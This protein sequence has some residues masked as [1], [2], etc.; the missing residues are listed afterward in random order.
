[1]AKR[2]RGVSKVE[3]GPVAVDGG[4]CADADLIT[5]G[6]T[7]RDSLIF[8][9]TDATVQ[10]FYVEEEDDPIDSDET[11]KG[12]ETVAWSTNNLEG[13]N[14]F[15]L[16]GG[17]HLPYK[18]AKTLGTITPGSG[19]TNGTYIRV[20]LTGGA[21]KGA[22]ATIVVAGGV[23]TS[24]TLTY[25]GEGYATSNAL[26]AS[27]AHIGG[28]GSGFS[29]PITAID[30]ASMTN[31]TWAPPAQKVTLERSI[32]LTDRKGNVIQVPRARFNSKKSF[33]L[34]RTA[35]AKVDI[36]AR[37]LVP[38]KVGEDKTKLIYAAIN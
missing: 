4:M 20:P 17:V 12:V 14:M 21:G 29:V 13:R 30:N 28:T 38:D 23:V 32:K 27:A 9:E 25:G 6:D 2:I 22:E 18:T 34:Q 16:F 8:G 33:N 15:L 24:V 31:S 19:Y 7:V 35:M 36:S 1:M 3:I 5:L 11:Q 37:I 10:D 26:S